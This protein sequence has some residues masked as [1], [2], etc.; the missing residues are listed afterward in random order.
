M[1]NLVWEMRRLGR[2][3]IARKMAKKMFAA[4]FQH[5]KTYTIRSGPLKGKR[6]HMH[7]D[8][9]FWMPLGQYESQTAGWIQSQLKP[10]SCFYDIGAN[11]GYFTILG[12]D[13]VGVDGV[14]QAF[15]PVPVNIDVL[16]RQISENNLSNVEL[17]DL[18]LSNEVGSIDF[19]VESNN[20]NSHIADVSITHAVS[21]PSSIVTVQTATMDSLVEDG[22]RKPDTIKIDVEGAEVLVLQGAIE[23]LK[24]ARPT[25]LISTHSAQLYTDVTEL[26]KELNYSV[27][28]LPGFEHEVIAI[29]N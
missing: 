11:A 21:N 22:L 18:A 15:E 20:A 10:G 5:G 23:T 2:I 25:L 29:P 8:H 19:A 4:V 26:L 27:S 28:S 24:S 17:H 14:V 16:H 1:T 7:R 9:Q 13:A 12:S 6:W 3:P